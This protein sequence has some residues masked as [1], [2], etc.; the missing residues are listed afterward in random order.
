MVSTICPKLDGNICGTFGIGLLSYE[1]DREG[2][3]EE[4]R[5]CHASRVTSVP[6]Q[7]YVEFGLWTVGGTGRQFNSIHNILVKVAR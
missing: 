4:R 7:S 2:G 3:E 6:I 5:I 1:N